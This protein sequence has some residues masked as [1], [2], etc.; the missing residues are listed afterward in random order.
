V[1]F[2]SLP[3]EALA[4]VAALAVAIAV[5]QAVV[6]A[7]TRWARRRRMSIRM[8]RARAGEDAAPALL[9]DHGY[10]VLGS[11]AVVEHAV[12]IDGRDV[13]VALRADYLAEKRGA[14]YVVEV[15][16]GA[17]A[18][19]IETSATRRQM[20][21]YRIAF[22]VDGVVLV[23]AESGRVHEVTF[24]ALDRFARAPRGASGW[25][26]VAVA[27]AVAVLLVVVATS[28]P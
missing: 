17:V 9:E 1:N 2:A 12:R 6:L 21:E 23:D 14:R 18:P 5:V 20:L 13:V 4:L 27:V 24:P 16:T 28:R 11:Q 10:A 19:R 8:E 3:P 7:G 22:D 26:F 25:R 15:K